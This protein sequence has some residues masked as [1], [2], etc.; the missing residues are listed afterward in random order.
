MDFIF[1]VSQSDKNTLTKD[2][3]EDQSIITIAE[4]FYNVNYGSSIITSKVRQ[5]NSVKK[6]QRLVFPEYRYFKN[7]S[8]WNFN[9][10]FVSKATETQVFMFLLPRL[11]E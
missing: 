1:W 8:F 6:T 5:I 3:S 9:S 10:H 7:S 2:A 11:F 4:S